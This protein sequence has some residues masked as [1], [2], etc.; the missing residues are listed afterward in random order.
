VL[1]KIIEPHYP[2]A[3]RR[4]RPYALESMLRVHLMQNWFALSDPAMEEALYEIA[5]VRS[6]ARLSLNERS[7]SACLNS[8]PRLLSGFRA[9]C[10]RCRVVHGGGRRLRR[11]HAA[12]GNSG[13]TRDLHLT[14]PA[15]AA[16]GRQS[17]LGRA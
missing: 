2:V 15:R 5:S 9:G 1:L 11:T 8:F 10:Q 14:R 16:A 4:R 13:R 6:F 12:V 3:G 7:G 17:T